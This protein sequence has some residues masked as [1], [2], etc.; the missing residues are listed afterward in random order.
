MTYLPTRSSALRIGTGEP[1]SAPES[2]PGP[3]SG[4]DGDEEEPVGDCGRWIVLDH[5]DRSSSASFS[6]EATSCVG[7]GGGGGGGG[8]SGDGEEVVALL[9]IVTA[10]EAAAEAAAASSVAGPT[11]FMACPSLLQPAD[12]RDLALFRASL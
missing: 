11:W 2:A 10:A 5:S 4:Y 3:A 7:G 8:G 12:S 1:A 6:L 9:A